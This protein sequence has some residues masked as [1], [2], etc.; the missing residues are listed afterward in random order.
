MRPSAGKEKGVE[1]GS[2]MSHKAGKS[3]EARFEPNEL[4]SGD[5]ATGSLPQPEAKSTRPTE[6]RHRHDRD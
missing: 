1:A 4:I 3:E 5:H 6:I 2:Q